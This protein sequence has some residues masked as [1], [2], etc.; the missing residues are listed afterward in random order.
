MQ[1]TEAAKR[2]L[3]GLREKYGDD[4]PNEDFQALVGAIQYMFD[5]LEGNITID[6]YLLH[7]LAAC[8]WV[9]TFYAPG[10]TI[11]WARHDNVLQR[12]L[13]GLMRTLRSAV[14]ADRVTFRNGQ[15]SF[16]YLPI[17]SWFV[18]MVHRNQL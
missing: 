7:N 12:C 1:R 9:S 17:P 5:G 6:S 16:G 13:E 4:G 8:A 11:P 14:I 18:E 3:A 10:V 15:F 2:L